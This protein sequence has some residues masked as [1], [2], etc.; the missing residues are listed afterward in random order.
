MIRGFLLGSAGLAAACLAAAH[1]WAGA[2]TWAAASLCLGVLWLVGEIRDWHATASLGFAAS[3][4]LAA[5]SLWQSAKPGVAL[6]AL[7]AIAAALCAWDLDGLSQRLV[8]FGYEGDRSKL[9]RQHLGRLLAV[10]G[11]GLVLGGIALAV[12]IQLS[13]LSALLLSLLAVLGLSWAVFLL[14]TEGGQA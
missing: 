6:L 8:R 1:T 5:V 13:F 10:V 4:I 9:E 3:A 2:W 14:R 12:Q 11:L 7:L